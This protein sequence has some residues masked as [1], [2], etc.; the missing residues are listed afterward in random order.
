[1]FQRWLDVEAALAQAKA[2]WCCVSAS[3]WDATRHDGVGKG[4]LKERER[5]QGD[6]W[7]L[8]LCARATLRYLSTLMAASAL[9]LAVFMSPALHAASASLIN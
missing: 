6:P 9:S 4:T 8:L 3:R 5:L 1:M 2:E 7:S